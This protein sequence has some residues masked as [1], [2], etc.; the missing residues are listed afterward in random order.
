VH[1]SGDVKKGDAMRR[2]GKM[3]IVTGFLTLVAGGMT[4]NPLLVLLA[5]WV[6]DLGG[7]LVCTRIVGG[8][9]KRGRYVRIAGAVFVAAGLIDVSCGG[10]LFAGDAGVW[11]GTVGVVVVCCDRITGA[12]WWEKVGRVACA[13]FLGL[14]FLATKSR[15]DAPLFPFGLAIESGVLV[16]GLMIAEFL[17]G[18]GTQTGGSLTGLNT[19][20]RDLLIAQ[21]DSPEEGAELVRQAEWYVQQNKVNFWEAARLVRFLHNSRNLD[22]LP[23]IS[24]ELAERKDRSFH[25]TIPESILQLQMIDRENGPDSA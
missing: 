14:W 23:E 5:L 15:E 21:S 8:F 7:L 20:E 16:G 12:G 19:E 25:D 4:Q 17:T 2:R 3:L 1:L 13:L 9:F 22:S 18:Y 11:M 24:K 10:I 6:I